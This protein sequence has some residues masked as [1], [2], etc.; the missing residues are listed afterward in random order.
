MLPAMWIRGRN[1]IPDRRAEF[2]SY[3]IFVDG[4]SVLLHDSRYASGPSRDSSALHLPAGHHRVLVKF[5][6]DAT[7]LSV[8]L[9][10]QFQPQRQ[11]Q[12][13]LLP[14]PV[15]EYA[16]AM[17]A[18]FRGDLIGMELCCRWGTVR[19]AGPFSISARCFIPQ[20]KSIRRGLDAAWKAVATAQPAAL[21][22][23][24]KSAE[25][26]VERGQPD[27]VR[28]EVMSILAERPQSE[29]ALQLAF[30]LSRRNQA[31][32]AGAAGPLAG[33]T[34]FLLPAGG[35][36]EIL[37]LGRGT[38]QS[39]PDGAANGILR[40]GVTAVCPAAGRIRPPQ[41]CCRIPATAGYQKS[42]PSR[43]PAVPGGATAAGQPD[44]RGKA[45]GT[46]NSMSIA[47]K[48]T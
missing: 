10:P 4:K 18:Y 29:T 31:G 38:G 37:Q 16:R 43:G 45:S 2:R 17:A 23:R 34:S 28:A 20:Q 13:S 8:A 15:L 7:P 48:R 5:T 36:G 33:V 12:K 3:E 30:N 19:N 24:L 6:P 44:Q 9:H 1:A 25:S 41:R 42:S 32:R 47:C 22:A 35:S 14:E 27:A 26:A 39:P 11:Q 21:L 46:S 40:A